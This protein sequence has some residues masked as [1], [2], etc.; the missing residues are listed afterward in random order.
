M[1][2]QHRKHSGSEL[3]SPCTHKIHHSKRILTTDRVVCILVCTF[4]EH[5]ASLRQPR[6]PPLT[7]RRTGRKPIILLCNRY[8]VCLC[9]Q[10]FPSLS[11][12]TFILFTFFPRKPNIL[13]K[14][15]SI[16]ISPGTCRSI[17]AYITS[18][19]RNSYITLRIWFYS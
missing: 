17:S 8:H 14:R 4:I 9:G 10:R 18:K 16:A 15:N 13:T 3:F 19:D 12:T 7:S 2:P 5:N 1:R 11:K 6:R